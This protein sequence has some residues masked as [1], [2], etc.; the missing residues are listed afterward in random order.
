MLILLLVVAPVFTYGQ[1]GHYFNISGVALNGYDPVAFF[2]AGKPTLGT[3]DFAFNWQGVIWY[4]E[5]QANL[6]AFQ[7]NPEKYAPQY[8][9]YCA[10]GMSRGYKAPIQIET[11]TIVNDKLYFN[12]NLDVKE[13]WNSKREEFILKAD[14]NWPDVKLK[15]E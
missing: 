15:K 5:N 7:S 11:W 3:K 9:G 6:E 14:K 2:L 8:G 12:Y 4:F 13:T 1:Q 10:F